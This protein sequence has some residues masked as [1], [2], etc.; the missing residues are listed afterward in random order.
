[1]LSAESGSDTGQ[2]LRS[3]VREDCQSRLESVVWVLID[4]MASNNE[5][6]RQIR[7]ANLSQ[8]SE[9]TRLAD[10]NTDLTKAM[11]EAGEYDAD[12]PIVQYLDGSPIR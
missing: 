11:I 12:A 4:Q 9:V 6:L 3:P 2:L 10:S 1:M 8:L 7:D 5:L